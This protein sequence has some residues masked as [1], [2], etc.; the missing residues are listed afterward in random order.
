MLCCNICCFVQRRDMILTVPNVLTFFRM[1]LAPYLGYLVLSESYTMA[2]GVFI[3]AGFTDMV[4]ANPLFIMFKYNTSLPIQD[5]QE[6]L[7]MLI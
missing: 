3:F 6:F 2:C 4:S 5:K 1:L 7:V